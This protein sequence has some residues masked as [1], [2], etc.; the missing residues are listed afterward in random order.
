MARETTRFADPKGPRR[1]GWMVVCFLALASIASAQTMPNMP[2]M[3]HAGPPAPGWHWAED[4]SAFY[5]FN[6]QERKFR[7]FH[8]WE[9]QNWLMVDAAHPIARGTFRAT[10]MTSLEPFTFHEIGSPQVFQTGETFRS[11]PLI[12]YQHPHDLIMGLGADYSRTS[13][14]IAYYAGADLVG[15]PTLGPTPF[16]HRPSAYGNPQAPLSHHYLD[17]THITP[18]V[19]RGGVSA[20]G[21]GVEG[22]WFHGREPDEDRTDID[23]G[24]LDSYA[25]RLSWAR[26]PW[27]AQASGARLKLPEAITPYD[28]DRLTGSIAYSR[29]AAGSAPLRLTAVTFAFGQN[30]EIHGNFEAYLLEATIQAAARGLIYTRAESVD[31]DILD[32]GFH[33]RGVFHRHRHSQVGALTAGYLFNL[34][35]TKAG[36]LGVGADVTG[37]SVP[38]NLKDSYGSPSSFHV[39]VHYSLRGQ[40]AGHGH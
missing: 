11:A 38:D 18:G 4:A 29:G 2:G 10:A 24:A 6:G 9:S 40:S 21:V 37:Y 1:I 17:S 36:F 28:A 12:D 30:R 3:Q 23:L 32:A 22:S 19:V 26:G 34:L 8:A 20:H 16:M 25:L 14:A 7:D 39:F 13:G 27:S 5:G 31:K 35:E 15:S 33:P